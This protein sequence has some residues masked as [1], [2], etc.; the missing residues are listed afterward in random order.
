[1]TW[2]KPQGYGTLLSAAERNPDGGFNDFG[3]SFEISDSMVAFEDMAINIKAV[4]TGTLQFYV[5]QHITVTVEYDHVSANSHVQFYHDGA[6]NGGAIVHGRVAD[7][8]D[9]SR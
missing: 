5:W 3:L 8:P 6:D 1:M 9:E 7:F 4:S 2:V